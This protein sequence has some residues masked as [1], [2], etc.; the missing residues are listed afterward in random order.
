M[1]DLGTPVF[2]KASF[3]RCANRFRIHAHLRREAWRQAM[4]CRHYLWLQGSVG[5]SIG[6]VIAR[7]QQGLRQHA[8]V[9]VGHSIR[10]SAGLQAIRLRSIH[11]RHRNLQ[12]QEAMGRRARTTAMALLSA[13]GEQVPQLN[14]SNPRFRLATKVWQRLPLVLPT[15]SVH[16]SS[17]IYRESRSCAA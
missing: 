2:P 16:E 12:V 8:A 4:R 1:R 11:G 13:A 3:A 9:L 6:V 15:R 5:D 10:D 7:V 14:P 17:G